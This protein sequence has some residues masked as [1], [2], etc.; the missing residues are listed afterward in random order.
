VTARSGEGFLQRMIQLVEGARRRKTPNE[1]ALHIV[2]TGFTL[3]FLIVVATFNPLYQSSSRFLGHTLFLDPFI[4]ISLL[5]C[6]IP[7]TIGGLLPAI[8]IAG[9]D[10]MIRHNVLAVDPKA[11]EA[12]GDVDTLLLDKTGTITLGNRQAVEFFSAPGIEPEEVA[13]AA[14]ISSLSDETPEGKSIV[15]LAREQ[16][17]CSKTYDSSKWVFTP[18]TAKTRMSGVECDLGSFHKGA[19]DAIEKMVRASSANMPPVIKEQVEAISRKGGTPL[20]VTKGNV[21]LGTIFLKDI[22]KPGLK[23]RFALLRKMGIRTVM[24]TGDNQLTAVAIAAEAGVDECFGQVTPEDK[25]RIIQSYQEKGH[26]VA[27]TGDGSNDAPAL[28]KADV[29]MAM[30]SG[31]QAAREAANLIDLDSDPTKLIEAVG[32]GKQLLM[33]RGALTTF[34]IANDVAKYFVLIPVVFLPICPE[35]SIINIMGLHSSESACLSCVLFNALIILALVPLALRG[36]RFESVD[37]NKMFCRNLGMWG[38][39]GLLIPFVGIKLIDL[40]ISMFL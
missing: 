19:P 37:A 35:I 36:V 40:F 32:I 15:K 38:T 13:E 24:I 9:M 20:L 17:N 29:A 18:F 33:T 6:L 22:V 10:R 31:T 12:A 11:V 1:Q 23:E 34:S 7:T 2:L 3:V 26:L 4:A 16:Y 28:A 5:V 30:N 21:V 14:L 8:G 25:L 39:C 27:M